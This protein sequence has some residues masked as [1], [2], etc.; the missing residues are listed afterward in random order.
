VA[1]G[2]AL[3]QALAAWLWVRAGV[4]LPAL[5]YLGWRQG[6]ALIDWPGW[7]AAGAGAGA[8]AGLAI[9]LVLLN[10]ALERGRVVLLAAAW[11]LAAVL[12]WLGPFLVNLPWKPLAEWA[13]DR[14][15]DGL[16]ESLY[17]LAE[18][19]DAYAPPAFVTAGLAAGLV[20]GL[21]TG[22]LLRRWDPTI[23]SRAV[24]AIAIGWGVAWGL[25]WM[26]PGQFFSSE[27]LKNLLSDFYADPSI[28]PLP[29]FM[30]IAGAVAGLLGGRIMLR[31]IALTRATGASRD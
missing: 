21:L 16:A 26:V 30:C 28:E 24:A 11:S 10:A 29:I 6:Y 19:F 14:G 1:V 8:I 31:Q 2:W 25:A 12:A 17:N 5:E 22:L 7:A 13:A 4:P 18:R 3:A 23:G 9:G 15:S 20:G 27:N